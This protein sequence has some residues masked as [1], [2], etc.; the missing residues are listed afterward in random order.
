MIQYDYKK[1]KAVNKK[2]F[3]DILLVEIEN[4]VNEIFK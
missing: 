3:N 1:L 2:F 4:F